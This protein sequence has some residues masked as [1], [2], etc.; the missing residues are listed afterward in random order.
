MDRRRMINELTSNSR[1]WSEKDRALLNSLADVVLSRIYDICIH[2]GPGSGNF[3]HAGIPGQVGGSA[4]GGSAEGTKGGSVTKEMVDSL[5]DYQGDSVGTNLSLRLSETPSPADQKMIDHVDAIIASQAPLSR[6]KVLL[7]NIS[8][9]RDPEEG[10]PKWLPPV[11]GSYV[12]RG[13]ISTTSSANALRAMATDESVYEKPPY[14]MVIKVGEGVR[15]VDMNK[16]LKDSA[17]EDQKEILL[18]R[19]LQVKVLKEYG[20]EITVEIS[21]PKKEN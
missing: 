5:Q 1:S 17:F 9:P 8:D 14:Y 15:G 19:G 18:E 13:F 16:Y 7:R 11:G 4:G 2:G 20:R 21:K 6:D 12:D 10:R 3:G